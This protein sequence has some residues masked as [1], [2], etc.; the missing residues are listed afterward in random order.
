M[1][2]WKQQRGGI[3]QAAT[4]SLASVALLASAKILNPKPLAPVHGIIRIRLT[5]ISAGAY[6]QRCH[7]SNR[8]YLCKRGRRLS[9]LA[10]LHLG[11]AFLWEPDRGRGLNEIGRSHLCNRSPVHIPTWRMRSG[12][13][14]KVQYKTKNEAN[15]MRGRGLNMPHQAQAINKADTHLKSRHATPRTALKTSG[16]SHES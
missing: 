16:V 5:S 10:L 4:S 1:T 2:T 13:F 7:F 11:S 14:V 9:A 3:I 8:I 15:E 12:D 6:D